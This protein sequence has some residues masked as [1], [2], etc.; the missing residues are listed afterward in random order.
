VKLWHPDAIKIPLEDAG[1][2]AGGGRK[3]C[4][5]TTEGPSIAGAVGAFKANRSAPHFLVSPQGK[6]RQFIA[7]NQA[8]RTL[9][10]PSGPETNRANCIQIEMI[11]YAARTQNWSDHYYER[12]AKL[13]RWI[14]H[15]FNVPH[16][17]RVE[18][19]ATETNPATHLSG[20]AFYNYAGYVGHEHVPGND[21]Y[22]PG[23]FKINSF[24]KL[25]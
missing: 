21:H 24:L 11:G 17:C 8:A 13:C 15:Q 25:F 4:L 14:E 12:I 1:S 20:Q 23:K 22:D 9:E 7:L 6:L 3:I 18:F 19:D 16:I 2:F 10:H 5:H